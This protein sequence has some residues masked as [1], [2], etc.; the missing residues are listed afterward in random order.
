M[1]GHM[2]TPFAS[3]SEELEYNTMSHTPIINYLSI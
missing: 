3:M 1:R 2:L